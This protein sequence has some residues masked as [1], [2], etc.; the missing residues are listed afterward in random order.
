M[1][2]NFVLSSVKVIREKPKTIPQEKLT[3]LDI[4]LWLIISL[5]CSSILLKFT[6][7]TIFVLQQFMWN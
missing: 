3:Y 4:W 2:E 5:S 7:N 1:K 6:Q